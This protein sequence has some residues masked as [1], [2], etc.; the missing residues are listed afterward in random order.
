MLASRVLVGVEAAAEGRPTMSKAPQRRSM[1]TAATSHPYTAARHS[2]IAV[3]KH[4]QR[5]SYG[6]AP[7]KC[8]RPVPPRR[9]VLVQAG[10][11]EPS[12]MDASLL[13]PQLA[14]LGTV[15]LAGAYWWFALVPSARVRLAVNKRSG[16]LR[17]YLEQ[18][19]QGASWCSGSCRPVEHC[20]HMAI[21]HD[22]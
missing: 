1:T 14:V 9:S 18:L 6:C 13:L 22:S 21:T 11:Y 2:G 10:G 5:F 16:A 4:R 7:T 12:P 3:E 8:W 15:G 17:S 19:K 20:K